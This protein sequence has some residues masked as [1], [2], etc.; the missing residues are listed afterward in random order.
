M[1]SADEITSYSKFFNTIYDE[2]QSSIDIGRG[3]HY[4]ILSA[5]INLQG[6]NP[7]N[8]YFAIIWDEDHDERVIGVLEELYSQNKL[9]NYIAFGER[10][11]GFTAVLAN[12]I[13]LSAATALPEYL[14]APDGDSWRAFAL[15]YDQAGSEMHLIQSSQEKSTRYVHLIVEHI[16]SIKQA[17]RKSILSFLFGEHSRLGANS[18]VALLDRSVREDICKVMFDLPTRTF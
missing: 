3:C 15:P 10:K 18:P 7:F 4:S 8:W 17:N 6:R 11:G 14:S 2:H 16:N 1:K 9:H 13:A 5:Q 12:G